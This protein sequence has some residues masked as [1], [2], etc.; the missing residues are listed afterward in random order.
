MR[1]TIWPNANFIRYTMTQ[2]RQEP[3]AVQMSPTIEVVL[4][5]EGE[6]LT[7]GASASDGPKCI[8]TGGAATMTL[9][10]EGKTFPIC[11]TGCRDE[12]N[13]S[14]QKYIKKASLLLGSQAAKAKATQS[15]APRVSR[16]EDAF[17]GDVPAKTE[18][19]RMPD[20]GNPATPD[21]KGKI[22]KAEPA[23]PSA[24]VV[25]KGN[26]PAKTKNATD[27]TAATKSANRAAALLRIAQ[28]LAKDGKTDAA[29]KNF[30][31]IVKDFP[32]T[33]AAKTAADRIK[34]LDGH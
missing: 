23:A 8:V 7:G 30:Q 34:V 2:D 32:G 18:Q 3:G 15:A 22:E 24:E 21:S 6:S 13:E 29:L 5:K 11:C 26:S 17:A 28:N 1:L 19:G 16:F 33:P 25:T 20:L 27:K 9:T 31:Q 10:F 4:G 14:P 12:F